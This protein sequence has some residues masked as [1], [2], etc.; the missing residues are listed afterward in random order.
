MS[1]KLHHALLILALF[2]S[3]KGWSENNGQL[4]FKVEKALK[5][6]MEQS[7]LMAESLK[8]QPGVLPKTINEKGELVTCN[9]DWWVSGFFPGQLWYMYEYSGDEKIKNLADEFSSRVAGQQYTTDNHDVGFMIFCSYGNGYRLTGCDE[10]L[11]VIENASR[12]LSTRFKEKT[13]CIRSWDKAPWSRQWQYPVIID[14]MMN[15]ELLMWSS[16]KFNNRKYSDIAISHANT[17]MKN[18]F[19]EDGSSYHVVSYDTISGEPELKHTSQGYSHSS[20]WARGQAWGLYGYTMMFRETGNKK[21]LK[22][23]IKIAEFLIN[24]DNLPEDKIPYWDFNAP[25]IPDAKRDASAGAIMCSALIE[26]SGYVNKKLS[27]KYLH[28]AECQLS[29]LC[30]D[31]YMAE[32]GSNG[33]F[34]LKHSVGHMPNKSEVDVPLTYADYYFV[35]ALLRYKAL[36]SKKK[37]KESRP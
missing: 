22:Q 33:N 37:V 36:V 21:Y 16:K 19:R 29:A 10:Y 28:I 13:G 17:T 26:L 12:S 5:F 24:N 3:I 34:I 23:A 32:K 6:S 30:S 15:L 31:K 11:K 20:A 35:E 9:P 8:D 27:D 2:F 4:L 1:L 14:N 18:H 7:L 25:D